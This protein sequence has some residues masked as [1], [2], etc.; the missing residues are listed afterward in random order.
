M[1]KKKVIDEKSPKKLSW[2]SLA[3]VGQKNWLLASSGLCMGPGRKPQPSLGTVLCRWLAVLG[4]N[5]R[6]LGTNRQ[7]PYFCVIRLKGDLE[8]WSGELGRGSQT[9]LLTWNIHVVSV[10][11][12][13]DEVTPLIPWILPALHGHEN[14]PSSGSQWEE[15]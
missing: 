13:K 3:L 10:E 2:L 7:W 4:S 15:M 9:L 5:E 8:Q 11:L 1:E 14:L 6:C 12:G